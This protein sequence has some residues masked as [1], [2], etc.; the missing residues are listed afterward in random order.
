MFE[1]YDIAI[2]VIS[3][4]GT[5]HARHKVDDEWIMCN[6]H[7]HTSPSICHF[8]FNALY[9]LALVL[10]YGG[11]FPWSTDSDVTSITCIDDENPVVFELRRLHK[12][13]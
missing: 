3:Q 6:E 1:S 13:T 4:K 5:C 7:H 11:S 2:K 12:S 10:M 8:A 9:P